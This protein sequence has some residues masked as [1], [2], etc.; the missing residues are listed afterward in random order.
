MSW[1][2]IFPE[3]T[4][5]SIWRQP[6]HIFKAWITVLTHKNHETHV[7]RGNEYTL[8]H[9]AKLTVEQAKESLKVLS[10]PDP[11][12]LSQNEEGRRIVTEDREFWFVVNGEKYQDMIKREIAK[13]NARQRTA[14]WRA[15][16]KLAG[17]AVAAVTED[18]PE[19]ETMDETVT[20]PTNAERRKPADLEECLSMAST[21]GWTEAEARKWYADMEVSNWAKVDGTPFGNWPRE[22]TMAR[23]RS[24]QFSPRANRKASPVQGDYKEGKVYRAEDVEVKLTKEEDLE[25]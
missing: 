21:I 5:S 4:E 12:S 7:W 11:E 25:S 19:A 10:E 15:N 14:R 1:C 22:M 24:R 9:Q 20:A 23:T 8:A 16:R 2:P 13:E 6:P 3:I 18:K 17:Q